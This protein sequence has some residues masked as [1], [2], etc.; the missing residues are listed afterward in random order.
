M[1]R[2][3]ARETAYKL[4]FEYLFNQNANDTTYNVLMSSEDLTED[5]KQYVKDIYSGVVDEYEDLILIVEKYADKFTVDRMIRSDLA[6]LL[7]SMYEMKCRKDIPNSV[8]IN[9]AVELVKK[10]S[11]EKSGSYV[12]GILSS[13]YKE[14]NNK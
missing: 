10:Y 13:Y 6:A 2:I 4:I 1:S 9:E 3:V 14:L 12:N 7:L 8:S 11:T 5:D